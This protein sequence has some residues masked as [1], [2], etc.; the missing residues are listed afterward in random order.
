VLLGVRFVYAFRF[1]CA[2]LYVYNVFRVCFII[3]VFWFV[4][5]YVCASD[6][7]FFGAFRFLCVF[8]VYAIL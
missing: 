1:V 8:L 3:V 4:R 6:C 7:V 2:L 5:L